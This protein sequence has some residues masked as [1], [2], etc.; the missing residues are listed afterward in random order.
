MMTRLHSKPSTTRKYPTISP[1]R[2]HLLDFSLTLR[3]LWDSSTRQTGQV[4]RKHSS[5]H[6]RIP[7]TET[8]RTLN[9]RGFDRKANGACPSKTQASLRLLVQTVNPTVANSSIAY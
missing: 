7:G 9:T 5:C 3:L 1:R 2:V 4:N 8:M 6:T